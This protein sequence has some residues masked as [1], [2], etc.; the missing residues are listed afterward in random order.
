MKQ[1]EQAGLISKYKEKKKDHKFQWWQ[2]RV[3]GRI[4]REEKEEDDFE[5]LFWLKKI[6]LCKT[7]HCM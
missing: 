1:T 7:L 5:I 3:S 2:S 6:K 4:W